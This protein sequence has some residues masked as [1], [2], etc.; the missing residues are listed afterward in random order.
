M[1]LGQAYQKTGMMDEAIREFQEA[2]SLSGRNPVYLGGL[3]QTYAL[4]AKRREAMG[5]LEELK[6]LSKQRYV[7]A[8]AI[9]EVYIGLDERDQAFFW[10]RKAFEERDGW[11]IHLGGDPRYHP[12][13]SDPRFAGLL[14]R[15]AFPPQP[16][17]I[18]Y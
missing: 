14:H 5:V 17:L 2:A 4:V 1:F 12:L 18:F 10:L 15:N 7:A 13:R 11:L 16:F 9:A 8:R 3:G 6:K